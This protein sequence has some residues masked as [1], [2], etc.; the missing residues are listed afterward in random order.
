MQNG[1]FV[2]KI[3]GVRLSV[4]KIHRHV[5]ENPGYNEFGRIN[6]KLPENEK[7]KNPRNLVSG[8]VRQLDSNIAAQR[9]IKF[10]A[11]K[12]PKTIDSRSDKYF[13]KKLEQVI[14]RNIPIKSVFQA[15]CIFYTH[16]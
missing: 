1:G 11:W 9:H 15:H 10:I 13:A 6:S 5:F 4:A 16:F 2:N 14:F 12:V 3:Q 8:S 7:Y